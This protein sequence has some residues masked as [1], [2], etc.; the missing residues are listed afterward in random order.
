MAAIP[1]AQAIPVH[2][3]VGSS[4]SGKSDASYWTYA[5]LLERGMH[6]GRID[7]DDL[8]IAVPHRP[9]TSRTSASRLQASPR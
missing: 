4:G 9:T 3:L 1:D 8:G 5:T 7:T 6:V 2:W